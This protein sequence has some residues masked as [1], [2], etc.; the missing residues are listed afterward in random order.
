MSRQT[1]ARNRSAPMNRALGTSAQLPN[2]AWACLGGYTTVPNF[3]PCA[4]VQANR[5]LEWT[6]AASGHDRNS[7]G[8]QVARRW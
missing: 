4:T 1:L 8:V 2:G 7:L 6:L 5:F 3:T